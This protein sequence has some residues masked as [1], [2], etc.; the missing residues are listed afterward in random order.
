MRIA[1]LLIL[2][3]VKP[4]TRWLKRNPDRVPKVW[5]LFGF[6]PFI[7][8]NLHLYVA[9]YSWAGWAG[10]VQGAEISVLDGLAVALYLALP[11]SSSSLPFRLSMAL[12]L[13]AVL[14]SAL[15]AEF[16]TAALLYASGSL[17]ACF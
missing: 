8:I 7:I 9:P 3:C 14:L 11:S 12:Y 1:I 4:L 5:A 10:Y 16:P 6:L 2:V 17:P 15:Q 13:I